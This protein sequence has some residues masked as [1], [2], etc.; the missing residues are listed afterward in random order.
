MRDSNHHSN[1]SFICF[2][3]ILYQFYLDNVDDDD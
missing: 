2:Y 1:H 3:L